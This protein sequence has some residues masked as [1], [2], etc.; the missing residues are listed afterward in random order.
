MVEHVVRGPTKVKYVRL[1]KFSNTV[2]PSPFDSCYGRI[3][4]YD[5][6]PEN[7][8][9]QSGLVPTAT[10]PVQHQVPPAVLPHDSSRHGHTA[11]IHC[12]LRTIAIWLLRSRTL[13]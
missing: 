5:M 4:T 1:V 11:K 6:Y 2:T 8:G 13:R 3:N 12:V 10:P 9:Q 7:F